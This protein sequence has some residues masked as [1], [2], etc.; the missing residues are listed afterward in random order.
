M[1]PLNRDVLHRAIDARFDEYMAS[2]RISGA[3]ASVW[4]DGVCAYRRFVGTT[5]PGG[6]TP[7]Q[8]KSLFRLASMTKPVTAVAVLLLAEQY[9]LHLDDPIE[10]YLPEFRDRR[11]WALSP[12]GTIVDRGAVQTKPTILHL[13][14]H[15]S[16][17]GGG[18]LGEYANA[19]MPHDARRDLASATSYYATQGLG[20]EPFTKQ[21]YSPLAAFDVLARIVELVSGER[22]GE[23]L[24][25]FIFDRCEMSDTTFSPSDEQWPHLVTMHDYRDG[26][27]V[28]VQGI[29]GCVFE[30]YPTTYEVGG[31][32][33]ISTLDDYVHF[34]EMLRCGGAYRGCRVLGEKWT[35]MMTSPVVPPSVQAGYKRWGLSVRVI[36]GEGYRLLPVGAY[37]WG[38]VFGTYFWVD[39]VNRIT[40][41]YMRN[42]YYDG[43]FVSRI[44]H[45]FEEDVHGAL[46]G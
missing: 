33:L 27:A 7:V 19:Q 9:K 24:K 30:D 42:S 8:E 31:A 25:R 34:A 26:K 29:D 28:A 10:K 18:A 38:G 16:G 5:A 22:F 40:A 43:G 36:V 2:G 23:F 14:T 17:L 45:R 41:V 6:D 44:S 1:T 15:T 12:D 46:M 32:G 11:L 39:P 13:L 37:G 35:R 21:E 4:Q 20:F 3:A